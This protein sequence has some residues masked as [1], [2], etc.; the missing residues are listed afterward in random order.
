MRAFLLST[1]AAAAALL[2]TTPA[3][4]ISIVIGD[5]LASACYRSA[6]SSNSFRAALEE[7]DRA[8]E[9]EVLTQEDRAAT[10]VN[11]GVVK[12][13]AG[14]LRGADRD[15]DTALAMDR[16]RAEAYLNKGFLRLMQGHYQDALPYFDQSLE[17]RTIRP[18]LAHYAR[19]IVHEEM[20]NVRAAYGDYVRARDL[21]PSWRLPAEELSR[22]KVTGR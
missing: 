17:A 18:A 5:S 20:G 19:G 4:A 21:D 8:I 3:P 7:C 12:M 16:A 6:S 9:E 11:R 15:F 1:A 10:L 13:R 22:F 2:S 14:D